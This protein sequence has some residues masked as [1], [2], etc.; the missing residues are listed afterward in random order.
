VDRGFL[1][2]FGPS[3]IAKSLDSITK[4][5]SLGQS[6]LPYNYIRQFVFGSLLITLWSLLG[7]AVGVPFEI[8]LALPLIIL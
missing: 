2:I 1:E 6:G 8:V 3:G 4:Q 7:N 5:V